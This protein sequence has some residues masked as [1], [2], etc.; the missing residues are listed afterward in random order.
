MANMFAREGHAVTVVTSTH[1]PEAPAATPGVEVFRVPIVDYRS[2]RGKEANFAPSASLKTSPLY[3][4][5]GKLAN[6]FPTNVLLGEGGA[7]YIFNCFHVLEPRIAA[8][9]G[10]GILFSTFRPWADVQVAYLLKSKFPQFYW[11]CD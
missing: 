6:S 7:T 1:T 11:W 5:F 2:R 9:G 10:R 8:A 4:V 3:Q